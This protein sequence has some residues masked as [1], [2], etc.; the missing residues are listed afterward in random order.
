M[1][2]K[3]ERVVDLWKTDKKDHSPVTGIHF[4][5]EEDLQVVKDGIADIVGFIN[6]DHRGFLLIQ[7]K[8][9]DLALD[10]VEV[11]CLP[12]SSLRAE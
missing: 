9:C 4:E 7:C 12:V 11:L 6:D 8:P 2:G 5:V 3:P 10:C 1:V